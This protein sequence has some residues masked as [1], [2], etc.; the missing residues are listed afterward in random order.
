MNGRHA[1]AYGKPDYFEGVPMPIEPLQSLP[2]MLG[3]LGYQTQAVGKM[4]FYPQRCCYGF[5][6]HDP[7]ESSTIPTTSCA[8]PTRA[9]Q[10]ATVS[11]TTRC[12]R[13]ARWCRRSIHRQRGRWDESVRFL[14]WRDPTRP[15]FL[16]T[17]FTK[18]HPP[19]D[20]PEP[21]D[22]MYDPARIA[23]PAPLPS[24]PPIPSNAPLIS[25]KSACPTSTTSFRA[26]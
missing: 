8:R 17:S 14:D 10:W 26:T 9:A 6:Q 24:G 18:P 21:Y 3:A 13:R 23:A 12:I 19:F 16:W 5:G 2:G 1:W 20:P 15:F 22:T 11:V 7:D 25:S 4:H